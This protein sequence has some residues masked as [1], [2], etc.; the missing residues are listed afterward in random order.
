MS[1]SGERIVEGYHGTR[2]Q[3]VEDILN[4]HFEISRNE[5][6][7]FGDGIYFFEYGRERA[8]EWAEEKYGAEEAAVI[9]ARV[10]LIDCMDLFDTK[11]T[12]VLTDAYDGFLDTLKQ[13]GLD[14]PR[15]TS[16]AH[17]LDGEVINYAIGE[18]KKQRM[19]I[20]C[21][22]GETIAKLP[23]CLHPARASC[24]AWIVG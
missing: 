4:H 20:R 23:G 19:V 9:G 22:R 15:Q 16:G 8:W 17:R 14:P 10:A 6:D 12:R 7:W 2:I 3:A 1:S 21:V 24:K 18:L 13:L 5:Y 11:W